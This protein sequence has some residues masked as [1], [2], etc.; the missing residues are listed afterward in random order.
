MK[1]FAQVRHLAPRM[2]IL[3]TSM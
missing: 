2:T 1:L 3:L